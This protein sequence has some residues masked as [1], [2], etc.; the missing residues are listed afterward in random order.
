MVPEN[1]D[2][3]VAAFIQRTFQRDDNELEGFRSVGADVVCYLGDIGVVE[4]S[5]NLVEDEKGRGLV[6]ADA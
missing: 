1:A 2:Q 6:A 5:I 3:G 4:R